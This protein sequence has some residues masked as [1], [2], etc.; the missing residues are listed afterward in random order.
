MATE[1]IITVPSDQFPLGTVFQQFPDV[2]VKLERIIPAIDR[3]I[4]YFWVRGT[5]VDDIESKFSEHP[6]IKRIVLI[7]SVEDEYLLRVEW[8]L[9]YDDVITVLT[10]IGIPLIKATGTNQQWT[11]KIRGD[12]HK[13]IAAFQSRC[14]ALDIPTTLTRLSRLTLLETGTEAQLTD[15]QEEALVLAYDRVLCILHAYC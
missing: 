14:R 1:A 15:T 10:E 7:D 8:R 13:D 2:E 6:G 12:D 11:F 4:P 9:E 5:V 3:V